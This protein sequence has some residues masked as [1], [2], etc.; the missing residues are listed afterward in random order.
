MQKQFPERFVVTFVDPNFYKSLPPSQQDRLAT[1]QS[2]EIISVIPSKVKGSPDRYLLEFA[3]KYDA[4]VVGKSDAYVAH[5]QEFPFVKEPGR[6]Y[7]ANRISE[8]S[9]FIVA[10][11]VAGS[12]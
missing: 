6:R 2:Q 10:A 8:G 5:E 3:R 4:L 1:L 7:T 9:W 11:G 12:K